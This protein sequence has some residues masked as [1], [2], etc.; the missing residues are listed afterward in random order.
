MAGNLIPAVAD[1]FASVD[2]FGV[3]GVAYEYAA[4]T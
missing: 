1:E 2:V 4:G 3:A